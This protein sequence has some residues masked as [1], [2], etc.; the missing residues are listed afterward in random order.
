MNEVEHL[1]DQLKRAFEGEA[2]HGPSVKEVL[3]NVTSEMAAAKP[4][5]HAHNIWELVLHITA[6]HDAV[7]KRLAG[8]SVNLSDEEDWP[9]VD[10]ISENAWAAAVENLGK[11]T[12]NLLKVLSAFDPSKLYDNT[13]GLNYTN[14]F[15]INGLIQHDVYHAGQI[16]LL[17]KALL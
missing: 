11:S 5:K 6:W 3:M 16:A 17:K 15:L 2:W 12:N 7:R 10:N 13:S 1:A 14:Y 8:L 9:S 4:I